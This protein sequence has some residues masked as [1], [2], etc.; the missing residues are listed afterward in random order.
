MTRREFY[1]FFGEWPENVIGPDWKNIMEEFKD[2]KKFMSNGQK[3]DATYPSALT[4]GVT[5]WEKESA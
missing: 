4:S 2:E 5:N 3:N 1:H